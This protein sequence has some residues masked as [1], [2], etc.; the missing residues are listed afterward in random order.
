MMHLQSLENMPL[1]TVFLLPGPIPGSRSFSSF[2]S[3]ASLMVWYCQ[4]QKGYVRTLVT[5]LPVE[6]RQS[7]GS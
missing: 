1:R 4:E 2:A 5:A 3:L 7:P 6:Y